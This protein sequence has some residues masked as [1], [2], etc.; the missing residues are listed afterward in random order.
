MPISRTG[1]LNKRLMFQEI[2]TKKSPT[3]GQTI[4]EPVDLFKAWFGY[5]QKYLNEVK[6]EVGTVLESTVTLII[7][8]KQ[9]KEVQS[10]WI[11]KIKGEL[12][13]IIKINPDTEDEEF[14]VLI[15]K[16]KA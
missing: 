12:F 3:T 4:K 13:D 8:Q 1:K 10:D 6:G 14:L 5:K 7:R 15:C 16:V 9:K 11:V 2:K